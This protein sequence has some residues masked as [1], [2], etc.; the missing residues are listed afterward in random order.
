MSARP[1]AQ[2][3]YLRF[4]L[5][6]IMKWPDELRYLCQTCHMWGEFRYRPFL[7]SPWVIF[8]HE[9]HMHHVRVFF[10]FLK[11]TRKDFC[12]VLILQEQFCTSELAKVIQDAILLILFCKT[13]SWILTV[14]S[15]TFIISDVRSSYIPS[16]TQDWYREDKFWATDRQYFCL[17]ILETKVTRILKRS[18]WEQ[19]VLHNTCIKHGI[20]IKA[21][22]IASTS[23]LLKRKDWSS[24]RL[25]R[26]QSFFKKHFQ[27]IVFR[28]LLGWKT[29]EIIYEKVY[30]SP[31]QPPKIYFRETWLDEGIGPRSCST[32]ER[33]P[34]N[35]TKPKS[36]SW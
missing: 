9:H 24:I 5:L 35:P 7:C 30:E 36:K 17:L 21:R 10:F 2:P 4:S 33:F 12:I 8:H 22:C 23:I 27:L 1:L 29:G 28:K 6:I 19:H 14:S 26:M 15:S 20:N 34:T 18:T 32:S 16:S 11:A 31:R 3:W 25:D 13:M